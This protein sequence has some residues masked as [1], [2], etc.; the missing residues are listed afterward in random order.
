MKTLLPL[1]AEAKARRSRYGKDREACRFSMEKAFQALKAEDEA[2]RGLSREVQRNA[3]KAK[4]RYKD[5]EAAFARDMQGLAV[6][7]KAQLTEEQRQIASQYKPP[8]LDDGR[9]RVPR[10]VRPAKKPKKI[11]REEKLVRE[12]RRSPPG[13]FTRIEGDLVRLQIERE[14]ARRGDPYPDRRR[15]EREKEIR[16]LFQEIRT[17]SE[18][19]FEKRLAEF[20]EALKPKTR[21]EALQAALKALKGGAAPRLGPVEKYLLSALT[22]GILKKRLKEE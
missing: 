9:V 5:L 12:V 1:A 2:D 7:A 3:T 18:G 15:G 21:R 10:T 4:D 11:S 14:E 20:C 22:A 17:L 8:V 16:V 13:G 19:V 6:K